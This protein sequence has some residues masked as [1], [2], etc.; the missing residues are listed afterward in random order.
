[1]PDSNEQ[2]SWNARWDTAGR[3]IK[4]AGEGSGFLSQ[5]TYMR[6]GAERKDYSKNT[7]RRQSPATPFDIMTSRE[8]SAHV[9]ER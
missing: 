2:F 3:N 4:F 1:V 5:D 8:N 6:L 9:R 7:N